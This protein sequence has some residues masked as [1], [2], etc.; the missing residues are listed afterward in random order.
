MTFSLLKKIEFIQINLKFIKNLKT[1]KVEVL[2]ENSF[3]FAIN[4]ILSNIISR[5]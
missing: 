5:K 4:L 1:E 3:N 2:L